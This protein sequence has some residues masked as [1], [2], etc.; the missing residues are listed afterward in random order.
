MVLAS[1]IE[2]FSN[3][4][5]TNAVHDISSLNWD[6]LGYITL[7]DNQ[8]TGFKSRELKSANIPTINATLVKLKLGQNHCNSHNNNNQVI[9]KLHELGTLENK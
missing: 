6:Y 5:D 3:N 9:K 4:E 7:S 8:N 2:L 1:K